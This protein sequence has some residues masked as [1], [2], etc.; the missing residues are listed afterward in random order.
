LVNSS[1]C[2]AL[3]FAIGVDAARLDHSGAAVTLL[4]GGM[5]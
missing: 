1:R 2:P 4:Y 5:P 3:M